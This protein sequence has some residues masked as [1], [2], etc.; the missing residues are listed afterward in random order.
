VESISVEMKELDICL[1]P[2][3][4]KVEEMVG[5]KRLLDRMEFL[6]ELPQ[7]LKEMVRDRR[8]PEAMKVTFRQF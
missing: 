3:R 5:V 4:T 8:F 1:A 6:L 2:N 7:K